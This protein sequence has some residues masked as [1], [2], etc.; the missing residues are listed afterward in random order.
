MITGPAT[1]LEWILVLSGV[2]T[3]LIFLVGHRGFLAPAGNRSVA[4]VHEAAIA[5]ALIHLVGLLSR[6]TASDAWAAAGIALYV[7]A[8]VIF[9]DG[10]ERSRTAALPGRD[11]IRLAFVAAWAAGPLATHSPTLMIAA[12]LMIALQQL[13][14]FKPS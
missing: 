1:P 10:I 7:L 13:V 9:L 8:M 12:V 14:A 4:F 11:R 5:G 6:R 2:A 3:L